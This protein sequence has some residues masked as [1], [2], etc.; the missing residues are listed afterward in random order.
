MASTIALRILLRYDLFYDTASLVKCSNYDYASDD[1]YDL[2][3]P[4]N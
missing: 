2:G 1:P 3:R 4:L